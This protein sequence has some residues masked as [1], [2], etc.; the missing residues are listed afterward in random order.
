MVLEYDVV[1]VGAGPS[2]AAAARGLINAGLKVLVIE[3]K[4]LPRYKICSGIIFKKSQELTTKY[5]GDIPP[6]AYVTPNFLKGVR[7]WDQHGHSTDWPFSKDG[8]GAPN[9]WRSEYDSWLI[10]N[11]RAEV[12]DCCNLKGFTTSADHVSLECYRATRNEKTEIKCTYLISAEGSRSF[13][14]ATLD[15][16]FEKSLKWFVAY[17]NYYEGHSDVD[18]YF[19]HGFLDPQY[20]D[21]YA[22][23]SIKDGLQIFGTAM[24][25]G[26]KLSSRLNHYT[27]ML[28]NKFG[29]RLT[30]LVRKAGCM[31]N[32]MCAT[33]RFYLGKGNVLLVGEAAGFLNAFGEGI[34]CALSTGLAAA[35][36]ISK[37]KPS[38]GDAFALYTELTKLE[39]RQ[40]TLSW[41]LGARIAGRNLMPL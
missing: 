21:V 16:S 1:V 40:T 39:R 41:K 35:E 32:D 12:W 4:K 6:S 14:R 33:G 38:G 13:I 2:G 10:K 26:N 3:K 34:S 27:K 20:G 7:F 15:P 23:F 37:G 24:K 30:K 17:Q 29:L 31:G 18:P 25:M 19:Y 5:F 22:W 11:S 28:E 8:D 36:A 9:I